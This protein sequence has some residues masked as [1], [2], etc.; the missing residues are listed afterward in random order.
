MRTELCRLT[1]DASILD[2]VTDCV[3]GD[4]WC[5]SAPTR[6][7]AW[8]PGVGPLTIR[9]LPLQIW[10]I[11][12]QNQPWILESRTHSKLTLTCG[13]SQHGT[14]SASVNLAPTTL[15][16]GCMSIACNCKNLACEGELDCHMA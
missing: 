12:L 11:A 16:I 10:P 7:P 2:V 13:P 15:C 9:S 4:G 3:E 8:G 1:I 14:H 6:A 5:T